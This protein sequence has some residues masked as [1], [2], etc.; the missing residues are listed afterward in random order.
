MGD[1]VFGEYTACKTRG[2]RCTS[3]CGAATGMGSRV[4]VRPAPTMP[5]R[6]RWRARCSSGT[7]RFTIARCSWPAAS[8]RGCDTS[9]GDGRFPPVRRRHRIIGGWPPLR[10]SRRSRSATSRSEIDSSSRRCASTRARTASRTTGTWCTSAAARSAAPGCV[11][12]GDRGHRRGPHQPA[13]PRH[14]EGRARRDARAHRR[15]SSTSRARSPGIQLAHAGRKASTSAP[16]EGGQPL[17]P[18]EG[19]WQPI[20]APSA[21]P[22]ADGYQVPQALDAAGIARRRRAFAAAARR[23]LD[24]G[25]EVIEIHA[26]HGYLL[27]EFLSPLSNQR[28]RRLRRIVRQPHALPPREVGGGARGLAGATAAVRAHLGHRLG[29]RRLGPSSESVA[30]ARQLKPLGV[31]LIDCSSGGI[32]RARRSRSAPGY[33]VPFAERDPRA[34]PASPTGAVGLITEPAQADADRRAAARPTWSC[35][36]ASCCAIRT[37]RCTRPSAPPGTPGS[38]AAYPQGRSATLSA[39]QLISRLDLG[40]RLKAVSYIDVILGTSA[41]SESGS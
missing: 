1:P 28:D 40:F 30:L 21:I 25:F 3:L 12:R 10:S 35:S 36:R 4:C 14:L 2:T 7:P 20:V 39:H 38:P 32:V 37:G 13:R 34:R 16:W 9:C 24:A 6:R 19:G 17:A 23:A 11:H 27:H 26:A 22:F 5:K 15:A 31:D 18:A 8:G 41:S 33:Q 29:R